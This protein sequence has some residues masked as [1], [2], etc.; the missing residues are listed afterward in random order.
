MSESALSIAQ[1][2]RDGTVKAVDVVEGTLANIARLNPQLNA[3]VAVT[4]DRARSEAKAVD[5]ARAAG[6]VLP[7]LAGVPYA[8]KNLFDVAG[9]ATLAGSKI[10]ASHPPAKSDAALVTR[11][12]SAGAVLVGTLNMDEFAYGFTTENT[13]YGP[14]R[15]PH[16]PE[17]IAGGSS[18]GSGAAAA[19][20]L[21]PVTLA[22]DTNGS[23]RVP[24]SLCGVWGLKPTYGRLSRSGTF[25]FVASLDHLG[26]IAA[27]LRDLAAAYDAMQGEDA[28]D[29]A[30]AQRAPEPVSDSLDGDLGDVRIAR[31]GGWFEANLTSDAQAAVDI[32]CKALHV[33]RTVT[34]AE[35][36]LGRAAAFIIG[37]SEG[38]N[39][40]LDDLRNR[41]GD[42][43]PLSRDR[44]FAG[45]LVPA[46][47]YV[48]AQ[49]IRALY[50]GAV[51]AHFAN[52]DVFIAAATPCA[53]TPIGTEW[54]D[55]ESGRVPL[56]PSM[57]LLT[58][59]ISCIGLP[60]VTAPIVRPGSL[61]LGVQVIAAPWRED[62]CFRVAAALSARGVAASPMPALHA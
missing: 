54:L 47:W 45:A 56:R 37:A 46:A 21:V 36:A 2:I 7:P 11:M 62:L 26:P 35:A 23:I 44:F 4:A 14:T 58:Q 52:T 49:R 60:V 51:R 27:D 20:R 48:Q 50:R 29:P 1:S 24:A 59:P 12:K 6:Q 22:S 15:N 13:H 31:L 9:L 3:F 10:N 19:A 53:A 16:D 38:G 40:H 39:L 18:G 41:R 30:C 33:T 8:V 55:L 25:P 32:A 61:P 17:R 5:K 34:W 28:S 43:E 57:G 42:M